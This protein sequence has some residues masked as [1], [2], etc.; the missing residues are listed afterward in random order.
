MN[1]VIDSKTKPNAPIQACAMIVIIISTN[2]QVMDLYFFDF[3]WGPKPA[4]RMSRFL[5]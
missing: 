2:D 5:L 4:F 3:R 1:D